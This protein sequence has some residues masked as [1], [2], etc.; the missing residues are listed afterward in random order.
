MKILD[1]FEKFGFLM[2]IKK[3]DLSYDDGKKSELYDNVT[4]SCNTYIFL[5]II[6]YLSL[7]NVVS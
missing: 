2:I 3:E 5:T 1:I 7:C 6:K 4:T